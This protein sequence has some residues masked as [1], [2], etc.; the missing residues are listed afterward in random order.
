MKRNLTVLF[1]TVFSALLILTYGCKKESGDA[2]NH[3]HKATS[4]ESPGT[5]I[6]KAD[7]LTVVFDLTT[8]QNHKKMMESMNIT[9]MNH[10]SDATH[11]LLLT[12]NDEKNET[13]KGADV[14]ISVKGPAGEV[15]KEAG[16][17]EGGGMYHYA[18]DLTA[19]KPGNY[20]V[21]ATLKISSQS[22]PVHAGTDFTLPLP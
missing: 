16:V 15:E 22:E 20:H 2:M 6:V 14:Q 10:D 19:K 7:G 1:T 17:M 18:V 3:D 8:M 4:L 5:K 13:V 11:E 12:V 9:N 21:E